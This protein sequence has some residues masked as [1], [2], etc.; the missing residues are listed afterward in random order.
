MAVLRA[1]RGLESGSEYN[2]KH[3]PVLLGRNPKRCDVVLEHYAVSREHARVEIVGSVCYIEDLKS[4]NGVRLNG[5]RLRPGSEGKQRLLV[6]DRIEIAAFE[7][8]V[9]EE[10]STDAL[11]RVSNETAKPEIVS[12]LR[13]GSDSSRQLRRNS[14]R[15]R[16]NILVGIIE[17]LSSELEFDKVLP[18]IV[19]G[20]LRAFPQ[21]HNGCVLLRRGDGE[22]EPVA[23]E[24]ADGDDEPV[25]VSRTILDEVVSNRH[26]ILSSD[27]TTDSRF[28]DS[29]SVQDQRLHSV[30]S[31]PLL[32]RDD[33]VLGVLQLEVLDRSQSFTPDDLELL[34]AVATHLAVV[35][36][37]SRLHGSALREQRTAF[38]ARFRKLVEGSLQGILIHRH[39]RPLFVNEAWSVLH[40]YSVE[41]VLSM[42]S[43]LHL[44]APEERDQA[45][46][47]A[48]SKL[49]GHDAPSRYECKDLRRDGTPVWVEKFISV[50]DWDGSPAIQTAVV[51]LTHRKQ[52]DE[53]VRQAHEE[54]EQRVADRTAELARS[55]RDL[56]QFA[57]SAAH[58]LQA[59]LRTV[60]SYCQ[61][62]KQ[63]YGDRLEE[64]AHEFLDGSIEG[65]KRMERLLDDLLGYSR[66]ATTADPFQT[67]DCNQVFREVSR[68]LT[69]QLEENDARLTSDQLPTIWCDSTQLLQLFQNLIGNAIAYRTDA[70]PRIHVGVEERPQDWRFSVRDNGVGIAPRHFERIFQIFQRLYAEHER[71]GSGVGL[72]LCKRIVERHG[73]EISVESSAGSGSVFSF[74]IPKRKAASGDRARAVRL[75]AASES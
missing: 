20:L 65:A 54:L 64:Q 74:T 37:N 12:T 10:P 73:G 70:P 19:S 14:K 11:V 33:V 63:R 21:A 28:A 61:L 15:G 49:Q 5:R 47:V 53:A 18:K 16:L 24:R 13:V 72:A 9:E 29:D 7:F 42:D 62:L 58:D 25:R 31:A 22:F 27:T 36:E 32:D 44:I 69:V 55:N 75:R 6:G 60:A 59:P 2:L 43:V 17:D 4:R 23:V 3:T 8:S 50:V 48:D 34:G 66:V 46:A 71:P 38:E 30:M 51:D 68:N 52:A 35:I 56:E 67:T 26:A 45:I 1:T 39:F 41:E 40:G 57:Y